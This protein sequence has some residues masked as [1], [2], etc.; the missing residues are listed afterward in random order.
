[1]KMFLVEGKF[2]REMKYVIEEL[3]ETQ[4]ENGA[5]HT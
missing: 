2:E 1:M 3:L 5:L 4:M